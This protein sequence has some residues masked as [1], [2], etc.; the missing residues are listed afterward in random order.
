MNFAVDGG[1]L[2]PVEMPRLNYIYMLI[3]AE[4]KVNRE[5]IHA[6]RDFQT[7]FQG[8]VML[9]D[10]TRAGRRPVTGPASQT[11]PKTDEIEVISTPVPS[12]S[13]LN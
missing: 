12:I 1:G 8:G 6:P 3:V 9:R 13:A 4:R 11:G 10:W 2:Y 7:V 5:T